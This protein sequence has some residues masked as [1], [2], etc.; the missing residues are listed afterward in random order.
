MWE[1]KV[2]PNLDV[3][4]ELLNYLGQQG[5]ELIGFDPRAENINR[6]IFKRPCK[7]KGAI[8]K[9]PQ[10]TKKNKLK[11]CSFTLGYIIPLANNAAKGQKWAQ[12]LLNEVF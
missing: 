8:M 6:L 4:E 5:W 7:Q 9:R 10:L 2:V 11:P 3:S 1:Y 12:T